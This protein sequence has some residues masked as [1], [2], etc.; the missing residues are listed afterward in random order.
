MLVEMF[1]NYLVVKELLVVK[2]K[3]LLSSR[4][5]DFFANFTF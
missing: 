5:F 4:I 1:Q 2:E 3:S